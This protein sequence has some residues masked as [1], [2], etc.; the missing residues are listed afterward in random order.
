MTVITNIF[1]WDHPPV[2]GF[3]TQK[4]RQICAAN[5]D[6]VVRLEAERFK[7]YHA[8]FPFFYTLHTPT[9]INIINISTSY[10]FDF[11][12]FF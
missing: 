3:I 4:T 10:W 11:F 1:K 9:S 2:S 7:T 5:I 6:E 8:T 12:S